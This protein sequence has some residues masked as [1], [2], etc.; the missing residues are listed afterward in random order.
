MAIAPRTDWATVEALLARLASTHGSFAGSHSQAY[1][2]ESYA[3]GWRLRIEG[4]TSS[5]WIDVE[6]IRDC[7]ATFERL[8]EIS[9]KDVLEPGRASTF[10]MAL[11]GQLPGVTE[12]E[13]SQG[14]S[15]LRV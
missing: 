2:I 6:D 12:V 13:G 1:R 11:F 7:W 14:E 10:M 5:R 4:A 8:G 3:P 15:I 9:K